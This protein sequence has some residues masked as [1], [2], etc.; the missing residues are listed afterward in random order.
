ML[1]DEYLDGNDTEASRD[2]EGEEEGSDPL[3]GLSARDQDTFFRILDVLSEEFGDRAFEFYMGNPR[4]IRALIDM[5]KQQ[6]I[7]VRKLDQ[8][9]WN[10]LLEAEIVNLR[11]LRDNE[12]ALAASSA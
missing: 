11:T 2:A 10:N 5:V 4:R 6:K 3:D 8:A 9:G 1:N 7:L 12:S